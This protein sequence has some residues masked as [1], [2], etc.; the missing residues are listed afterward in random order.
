[1][2]ER[3]KLQKA[4]AHSGLMSRRAAEELIA[5]GRV[6]VDGRPARI[7]QRVDPETQ[8]VAVDGKPIPIRP[9]LVWYLLYK[10]VGV[11]STADDPQGRRTVVD[12]VPSEPRVY[13]VGRLDADSEGLIVLTN[14]GRLANYLTHPRYGVEKTYLVLVEGRPGKWVDQLTE[15][16]DLDDGM[17]AARR[18]RVVDTLKGRTLVE[19]VMT[20]GRK[21]EIRRMCSA[22]GHEVVR[23]VRT[24]IG[25]ISD[26]QLKP[27][28]WR[29]LE[30]EE[31]AALYAAAAF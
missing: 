22:L 4:I 17:A 14:D 8:E 19:I 26:R 28:T 25:P 21:R 23:L 5:Q 29:H 6:T 30:P 9:G 7:G 27:G 20:E 24:A 16:V 15:G 10:P 3:P 18:A 1:M 11:I 2:D 13:P 31:V 12:L